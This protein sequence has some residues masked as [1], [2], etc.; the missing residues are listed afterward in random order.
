[1]VGTPER[2]ITAEGRDGIYV[3]DWW[4][5]PLSGEWAVG[6]KSRD[7][8]LC[9]AIWARGGVGVDKVGAGK[10]GTV[11]FLKTS[12][13]FLMGW[14]SRVRKRE[15]SRATPRLLGNWV[16]LLNWRRWGCRWRTGLI[17]NVKCL[18]AESVR[19]LWAC[20]GRQGAGRRR[21]RTGWG[22]CGCWARGTLGS[23]CQQIAGI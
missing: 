9:A 15:K 12:C 7:R 16:D 3:F 18:I 17:V 14:V 20:E 2:V 19:C 22:G 21:P 5:Q 8:R 11:M 6:G 23:H 1:M 10:M 4:L 13:G